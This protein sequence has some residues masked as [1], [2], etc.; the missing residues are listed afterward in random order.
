[1]FLFGKVHL[2]RHS[3]D[4]GSS[5]YSVWRSER[6]WWSAAR[7]VQEVSRGKLLPGTDKVCMDAEHLGDLASGPLGIDCLPH[8]SP[9]RRS[10]E[11]D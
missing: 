4:L 3:G 1:M 8:D 9:H 7:R 6:R 10:C 11:L 2:D 5:P